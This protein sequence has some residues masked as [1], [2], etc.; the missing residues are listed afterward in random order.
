MVTPD[1]EECVHGY[2][3]YDY[4]STRWEAD[5]RADVHDEA[6]HCWCGDC[7]LLYFRDEPGGDWYTKTWTEEDIK[8]IEERVASSW[9]RNFFE[10]N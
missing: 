4:E 7:G 8:K 5:T 6:D 1:P 3:Y 10:D 9:L 2:W